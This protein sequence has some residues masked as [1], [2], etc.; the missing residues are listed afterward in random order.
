MNCGHPLRDYF[1]LIRKLAW[2]K[3]YEEKRKSGEC[4]RRKRIV[5]KTDEERVRAIRRRKLEPVTAT[6]YNA[7]YKKEEKKAGKRLGSDEPQ[8][9][10]SL[11]SHKSADNYIPPGPKY[12]YRPLQ[13]YSTNIEALLAE[14]YLERLYLDKMFFKSFKTHPG[15]PS[16]N[17]QGAV[18]MFRLGL[19]SFKC[20]NFKQELLRTRR[21]YYYIKYRDTHL[22]KNLKRMCRREMARRIASNTAKAQGMFDHMVDLAEKRQARQVMIL[23]MKFRLYCEQVPRQMLPTRDLYLKDMYQ[24]LSEVHISLKRL[25]PNMYDWRNVKRILKML[26]VGV[27]RITSDDSVLYQFK[28]IFENYQ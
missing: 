10:D 27:A 17:I 15:I 4:K 20:L 25:N 19:D 3:A 14:T 28:D 5:K 21:P 16:P 2:L 8:I 1:K 22:T 9:A 13:R 18:R 12:R 7:L 26:G 23:A 24:L 6:Y 11:Y